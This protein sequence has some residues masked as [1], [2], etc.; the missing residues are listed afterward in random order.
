MISKIHVIFIVDPHNKR[1]KE[2][3]K[4]FEKKLKSQK[5]PPGKMEVKPPEDLQEANYEKL[6]LKQVVQVY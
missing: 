4:F 2:N 6:C 3:K 1:A 5:N